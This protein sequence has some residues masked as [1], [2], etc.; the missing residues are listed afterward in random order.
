MVSPDEDNN[1]IT[2]FTLLNVCY[3]FGTELFYM[4]NMYQVLHLAQCLTNNKCSIYCGHITIIITF[5]IALNLHF[6]HEVVI[7]F[8]LKVIQLL[9]ARILTQVCMILQLTLLITMIFNTSITLIQMLQND[10][11]VDDRLHI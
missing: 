3:L 2:S 8:M 11:S 6:F 7:S 5:I 1:K 9:R 4:S 10:V